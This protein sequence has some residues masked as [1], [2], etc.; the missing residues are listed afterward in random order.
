MTNDLCFSLYAVELNVGEDRTGLKGQDYHAFL[1]LVDETPDQ[2]PKII[3]ELHF[4]L[5][6]KGLAE[7]QRPYLHAVVKT[8]TQRDLS[9]LKML[10]YI[11]GRNDIMIPVWEHALDVGFE[12]GS[13]KKEF[14]TGSAPSGINCR[15]GVKAVI[16]RLGLDYTPVIK[17]DGPVAIG[18]ESSLATEISVDAN[19]CDFEI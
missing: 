8:D 7:G 2:Q 19:L 12:V 15:A 9:S 10:G 14:S 16:D 11:G 18:T 3:Q 17:G 13:L 6:T 4:T 5:K 1:A